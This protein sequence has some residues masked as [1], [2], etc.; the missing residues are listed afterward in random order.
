MRSL[1]RFFCTFFFC[2]ALPTPAIQGQNT[3]SMSARPIVR[4]K[5]ALSFITTSTGAMGG[6][7]IN[8]VNTLIVTGNETVSI[9]T[10]A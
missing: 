5:A 2:L 3:S 7:A 10:R 9:S 4:D 1:V 8:A 6:G